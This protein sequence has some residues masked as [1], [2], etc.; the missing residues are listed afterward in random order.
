LRIGLTILASEVASSTA[1]RRCRHLGSGKIRPSLRAARGQVEREPEMR[2]ESTRSTRFSSL[3]R[4]DPIHI[5][6]PPRSRS[7]GET[8][9]FVTTARLSS[10][11]R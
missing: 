5:L 3:K 4:R 2:A 9:A 8:D 7:F 10:V 6:A 11:R 1:R